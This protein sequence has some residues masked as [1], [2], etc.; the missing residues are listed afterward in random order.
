MDFLYIFLMIH[1]EMIYYKVKN[2]AGDVET[3]WLGWKFLDG[4]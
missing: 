2:S 1:K 3:R 4:L